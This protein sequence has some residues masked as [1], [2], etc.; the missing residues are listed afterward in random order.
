MD[1][2]GVIERCPSTIS[3]I[4]RGATPMA[5][6]MAFCEIPIGVRYSS[7]R[8]S[9][10]MMGGFMAGRVA[11]CE[12]L[13]TLSPLRRDK[14]FGPSTMPMASG[15]NDHFLRSFV[16]KAATEP[17]PALKALPPIADLRDELLV[18]MT[19]RFQSSPP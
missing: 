4:E 14:F 18:R 13:H 1:M 16:V 2:T 6:A 9:P 12:A 7:S 8:I 15:A 19:D 17:L 11:L 3:L 5:R 10:G